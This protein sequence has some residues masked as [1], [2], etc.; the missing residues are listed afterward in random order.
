M[1]PGGPTDEAM[2][3]SAAR[4]LGEYFSCASFWRQQ[5]EARAREYQALAD[6]LALSKE[7]TNDQARRWFNQEAA[8]KETLRVA[9]KDEEAANKRL[10]EADQ[11]YTELLAK[12]VPLHHEEIVEL[13]AVADASKPE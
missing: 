2:E 3:E 1:L 6:E 9:Q 10:H 5:T 8:I 11:T 7:Q 4:S 13:K 12:V